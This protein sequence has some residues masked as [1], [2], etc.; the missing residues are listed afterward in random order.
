MIPTQTAW[1]QSLLGEWRSN[2]L[3]SQQKRIKWDTGELL[4][5]V[6]DTDLERE[7]PVCTTGVGFNW[8]PKTD[9]QGKSKQKFIDMCI[10]H[11]EPSERTPEKYHRTPS[12]SAQRLKIVFSHVL[13]THGR[14]GKERISFISFCPRMGLFTVVYIFSWPTYWKSSWHFCIGP[15][16]LYFYSRFGALDRHRCWWCCLVAQSCP[17][18]LRPCGL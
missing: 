9:Y 1:V 5:D 17:T 4:G 2:E 15:V 16:N 10:V 6:S 8:W 7:P 18:L 13:C 3:C 12:P 11:Q 14:R